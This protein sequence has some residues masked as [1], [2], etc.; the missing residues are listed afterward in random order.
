MPLWAEKICQAAEL[1]YNG[2][3]SYS[4]S[5]FSSL[6]PCLEITVHNFKHLKTYFSSHQN[7]SI[8]FKTTWLRSIYDL[9]WY[10]HSE[11]Q[12]YILRM[13]KIPPLKY[14]KFLPKIARPSQRQP[15]SIRNL[16][17]NFESKG[18][19]CLHNVQNSFTVRPWNIK[20]NGPST[21]K[22]FSHFQ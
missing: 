4:K 7:C 1:E 5:R 16:L 9:F 20:I 17:K 12:F 19:K 18:R 15:L 6:K 13:K 11:K 10:R 2:L 8:F 3:V 22:F 21:M 14:F